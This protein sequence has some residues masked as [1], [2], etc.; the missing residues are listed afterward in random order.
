MLVAAVMET[1]WVTGQYLV[2]ISAMALVGGDD[3]GTG[4][5]FS[6]QSRIDENITT[7]SRCRVFVFW[8]KKSIITVSST[9]ARFYSGCKAISGWYGGGGI[10]IL[11]DRTT[12]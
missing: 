4:I 10:F 5:H 7:P 8:P 6:S 1:L 2:L 12:R 3:D 11:T 9:Y